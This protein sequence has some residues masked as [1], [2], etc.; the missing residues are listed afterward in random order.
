MKDLKTR[1]NFDTKIT[2]KDDVYT[3]RNNKL[4]QGKH[5][6]DMLTNAVLSNKIIREYLQVVTDSKYVF[7]KSDKFEQTVLDVKYLIATSDFLIEMKGWN[8]GKSWRSASKTLEEFTA[9]IDVLIDKKLSNHECKYSYNDTSIL[10]IDNFNMCQNIVLDAISKEKI[11]TN[12]HSDKFYDAYNVKTHSTMKVEKL[13]NMILDFDFKSYGVTPKPIINEYKELYDRVITATN[14]F[15]RLIDI[16]S[17]DIINWG[18]HKLTSQKKKHKIGSFDSCW[19]GQHIENLKTKGVT[20]VTKIKKVTMTERCYSD[21]ELSQ[22][23]LVKCFKTMT[24]NQSIGILNK[25]TVDTATSL[26]QIETKNVQEKLIDR[27]KRPTQAFEKIFDMIASEYNKNAYDILRDYVDTIEAPQEKS[28]HSREYVNLDKFCTWEYI[29]TYSNEIYLN[30]Y[31]Y[32]SLDF[33][34]IPNDFV[35]KHLSD[36]SLS[37]KF[38]KNDSITHAFL[39]RMT[40]E[41]K[42]KFLYLA[43]ADKNIHIDWSKSVNLFN[44]VDYNEVRKIINTYDYYPFVDII[45]KNNDNE[46]A[47]E[48]LSNQRHINPCANEHKLFSIL[49]FDQKI[50]QLNNRTNIYDKDVIKIVG[51]N[52]KEFLKIAVESPNL[53]DLI[54]CFDK[55]DLNTLVKNAEFPCVSVKLASELSQ[56]NLVKVFK[57]GHWSD[58]ENRYNENKNI[59]H[60]KCLTRKSFDLCFDETPDNQWQYSKYLTHM[61]T[62]PEFLNA[63]DDDSFVRYNFDLIC[64]DTVAVEKLRRFTDKRNFKSIVGDRRDRKNDAFGSKLESKLLELTAIKLHIVN[65]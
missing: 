17:D 14:E 59:T 52:I 3:I 24:E 34:E 53:C 42:T 37:E 12:Y 38:V 5:R 56:E 8:T 41:E 39:K 30:N 21:E 23:D 43:Q 40:T 54:D 27:W 58:T 48:I 28:W 46:I 6:V 33:I 51:K 61:M 57:E 9:K 62:G 47:N 19:L 1:L 11:G 4:Y 60:Y 2:H 45:V 64:N 10:D 22:S 35:D 36:Y 15:K 25:M 49:S 55:R 44:D 13:L 65:S 50:E 26:L 29:F 20:K 31:D 18:K 16:A 32:K 7:K 63:C